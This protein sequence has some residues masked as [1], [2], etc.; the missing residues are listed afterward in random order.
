MGVQGLW[1]L[2]QSTGKPV[3]LL[4]LD[5]KILS[6]DVSI[7]LHH[8]V[9]GMRD[10]DGN[11]LPNAHLQVL[12]SRICKLLFYNI[13]PVFVFDGGVPVLKKQ[14]LA[15]RRENRELAEK[16][17]SKTNQ[18]LL[19]NLMKSQAIKEVL[20]DDAG[21]SKSQL[22]TSTKSRDMFELPPLPAEFLR[23]QEENSSWEER[24]A[25]QEVMAEDELDDIDVDSPDFC[26]LPS[27]LKHEI[28][29][30]M[31]EQRKYNLSAKMDLPEDSLDFSSY[32]MAKILK[33]NKLASKIEQVRKEM[34]APSRS[35]ISLTL[36]DDYYSDSVI[37]SQRVIS[38]DKSHFVLI[39]GTG[40][41]RR[42]EELAKANEYEEE[43]LKAELATAQEED[44]KMK[45]IMD[46]ISNES[47]K[48]IGNN[49]DM[50]VV[51]KKSC[52]VDIT[53]NMTHVVEITENVVNAQQVLTDDHTSTGPYVDQQCRSNILS[54]VLNMKNK[55]LQKI[56]DDDVSDSRDIDRPAIVDRSQPKDPFKLSQSAEHSSDPSSTNV[57]HIKSSLQP[58]SNQKESVCQVENDMIPMKTSNLSNGQESR[59]SASKDN[60]G[61]PIL[62]SSD[63]DVVVKKPRLN[64]DS[65][66]HYQQQQQGL[67]KVEAAVA[68][69]DSRSE[70]EGFIE[71][72]IDTTKRNVPDDLFPASIF[73]GGDNED[74]VPLTLPSEEQ[75]IAST[76]A[77]KVVT[78]EEPVGTITADEQLMD[79]TADQFQ[80]PNPF[81]DFKEDDLLEYKEDLELESINLQQ[82]RGKQDRL[83]TSI[84]DQMYLEAQELLQMFGVPY[85]VSPMEAEAQCAFMDQTDQTQGSIT[86]D[87][88]IWLFGGTRVYKNFFNQNKHVEFF[89][90]T[91]IDYQLGLCRE[92]MI[93]IALLC[94]S[95]YTLGIQKVGPVSA[96]E[97]MAEF[98]GDGV[99]GLI[100]FKSWWD[101]AR[102]KQSKDTKIRNKLKQLD[103][104]EGFPSAAVVDAY[105]SPKVDESMDAFT[106]SRP[107]LD[108]LRDYA[109]EKFGWR[110][111]KVDE[112]LLPVMKRLNERQRQGKIDKFFQP[113]AFLESK[114]VQ[115]SRVKQALSKLTSAP[116]SELLHTK[117]SQSPIQ[118]AKDAMAERRRKMKGKG[119]SAGQ[120]LKSRG[121]GKGKRTLKGESK[122]NEGKHDKF[123]VKEFVELS[124][125]SSSEEEKSCAFKHKTNSSATVT[126]AAKTDSSKSLSY[127]ESGGF[128]QDDDEDTSE[129]VGQKLKSYF[130]RLEKGFIGKSDVEQKS[131]SRQASERRSIKIS[132]T[133]DNSVAITRNS[134]KTK[135]RS[136][137]V[138]MDNSDSSSDSDF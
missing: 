38:E 78:N 51:S 81:Q 29:T 96:L 4:S 31:K 75:I 74:T 72:S 137:L 52:V 135:A 5:G 18:K 94:G 6:I 128:Y 117:A 134:R 56:S 32:Q 65:T 104:H 110:K 98:P 71:I 53:E 100:K 82:E 49:R 55:L 67:H 61:V 46:N 73:S 34:N 111:E 57:T 93:N 76:S 62:I 12:F 45:Q 48:E 126:S 28:L 66:I 50:E 124:E 138:R 118:K 109:R 107:D 15:F 120:G 77:Q 95:D 80:E 103:I 84:T 127:L 90:R 9:K 8:A 63:D 11:P 42:E 41:Q 3:S 89:Q 102:H 112:N 131:D 14:T 30:T 43:L 85:V 123:M 122:K 115:S 24:V 16:E 108:L 36:G 88:D 37:Q 97:I 20:G 7:W 21:P 23:M 70:D 83:A 119:I 2:I 54:E 133:V 113:E 26:S 114:K 106:W 64:F 33:Q 59:P 132:K 10:K 136:K 68:C 58:S 27:E 105:L 121:K 19:Q 79:M 1:Q 47:D 91:S 92:K 116:T 86:D 101:K 99:E 60:C 22:S 130:D 125:S 13:K 69:D 17:S 40:K 44:N 25:A 39:K 87:S 129:T 35:E